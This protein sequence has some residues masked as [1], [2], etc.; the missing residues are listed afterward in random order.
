MELVYPIVMIIGIPIILVLLFINF[1]KPVLYSDGKKI[2]NTKYAQEIPYYKEIM[3]KYKFFSFLIKLLI[4]IAIFMALLLFARPSKVDYESSAKYN[5]DIFLCMDISTTVNE[6]N[7]KLVEELK[8]TVKKLKGERFGIL[9][10]NTSP[11]LLVPLTDDYEYII[12]TLDN[13]KRGLEIDNGETSIVD[14]D[15][16]DYYIRHYIYE[17]TLVD[18]ETRGGSLIGDGLASCVFKFPNLEEERSRIIIFSTDNDVQGEEIVSLKEAAEFAKENNITVF[19]IGPDIITD[20]NREEFEEVAEYTGGSYFTNDSKTTVSEIINNIEKKE[21]SLLKGKKE[22][23]KVDKPQI[24]FIILT[25]S[26]CGLFVLNKKV[27][28]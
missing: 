21:K 13:L 12:D 11:V 1:K 14:L 22:I 3:K 23:R 19:G 28:L 18:N 2:A 17:G 6:L 15:D 8:E 10:F 16:D 7:E 24:P 5:R 27:K 25:I 4:I 9:I 26:I 20:D